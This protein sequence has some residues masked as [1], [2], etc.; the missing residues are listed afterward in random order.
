MAVVGV[1][2]YLYS[3]GGQAKPTEAE[4]EPAQAAAPAV[5][6]AKQKTPAD[7]PAIPSSIVTDQAREF[8]GKARR[9]AASGDFAGAE[10]ALKKAEEV[11][12]GVDETA[13]ARQAI[14]ELSKPEGQLAA[15]LNRARSALELGDDAVAEQ[16]IAE[17]ERLNAP[18]S[19]I[20][21]L[22]ANL[23][24]A[25]QKDTHQNDH[26]ASLLAEMRTAAARHDFATANRALNEAER[27]DIQNRDVLKARDELNREQDTVRPPAKN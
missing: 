11:A 15:Q 22:R 18:A 21:E 3:Y 16:A 13:Q 4:A 20:A 17:A 14:A 25:Q 10:A 8:V 24:A 27:L 7:E 23:Q 5:A 12:P 19:A 2:A 6:A 1:G 9:L 26:I